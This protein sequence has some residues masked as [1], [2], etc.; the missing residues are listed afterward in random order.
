MLR[1][2]FRM[3]LRASGGSITIRSARRRVSPG[4][5]QDDE[6]AQIRE[7]LRSLGC[8]CENLLLTCVAR[9]AVSLGALSSVC[10]AELPHCSLVRADLQQHGSVPFETWVVWCPAQ[11][12]RCGADNEE[13]AAS[14]QADDL[15][16]CVFSQCACIPCLCTRN[17]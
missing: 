3:K 1:W 10:P 4:S 13:C 16:L 5:R 6:A 9:G 15:A 2:R 7:K 8:F 11:K 17:N 14:M 12:S